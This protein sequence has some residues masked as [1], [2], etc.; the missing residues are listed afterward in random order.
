MGLVDGA[1]LLDPSSGELDPELTPVGPLNA[2]GHGRVDFSDATT[3]LARAEDGHF[4]RLFLVFEARSDEE[5]S[6][7]VDRLKKLDSRPLGFSQA[8]LR[9]KLAT[10]PVELRLSVSGKNREAATAP[11]EIVSERQPEAH[12]TRTHGF[13]VTWTNRPKASPSS[14]RL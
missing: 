4:Q 5:S 11:L 6:S 10:A 7:H 12:E 1:P 8:D 2:Q 13:S 9:Q 3:H 14:T